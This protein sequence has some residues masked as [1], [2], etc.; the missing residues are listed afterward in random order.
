MVDFHLLFAYEDVD[1]GLIQIRG[2][3]DGSKPIGLQRGFCKNDCVI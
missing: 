2:N 1:M 3:K